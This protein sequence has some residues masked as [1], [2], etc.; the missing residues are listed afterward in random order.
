LATKI[1]VPNTML[2]SAIT[3]VLGLLTVRRYR[4]TVRELEL[5]PAV[6]RD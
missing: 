3:L 6:V 4:L 5:A 1:G 2:C